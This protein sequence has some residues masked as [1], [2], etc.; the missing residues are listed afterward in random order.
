MKKIIYV[1]IGMLI[2]L[3][4]CTERV[5]MGFVCMK[6]TA[7]KGIIQEVL[8]PGNHSCYG[9]DRLALIP[10][11]EKTF[12][13]NLSV[14]CLDDLNFKFDVKVRCFTAADNVNAMTQLLDR[15]GRNII[16]DGAI[17]EL[18]FDILYATY[19]QPLVRSV[20]RKT[21]SKYETTQIREN[22]E[23]I[24]KTI[25]T[26][27]MKG[28]KNTPLEV[29]SILTSNF[30]YPDMIKDAME[31]KKKYQIKIEEEKA[32]QA[33]EMVKMEN[34]IKLAQ[35]RKILRAAEAEA[36]ETYNRIVGRSL[37]TNY[38]K[39]RMIE[40]DNLLYKNVQA[41][42]KVIV[43]DGSTIQPMIDTRK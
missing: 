19:L 2:V 26:E 18:P 10:K 43:T 1:L 35:K 29:V 12:T 40:R 23:A 11:T 27:V 3:S 20:S 6:M 16:W 42:D 41:G 13:E 24:E 9:R 25:T 15:Q 39:L 33:A 14:L 5:P 8:Q 28:I 32:K 36:E 17:G 7:N 31:T 34:D 30:D 37:T 21:V 38:L 22:R 4:S